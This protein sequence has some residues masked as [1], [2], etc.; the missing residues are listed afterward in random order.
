[1]K[2]RPGLMLSA[3]AI[4]LV[5]VAA[6]SATAQVSSRDLPIVAQPQQRFDSGQDIQPIYE[7]WE[8]NDNGG[9]TLHFG[10][11]NRNYREQPQVP[12]G[13]NN[14]FSPGDADR[15]QPAYFYPRTQRY[16]FTVQVPASTGASLEDGLVWTVIHRGSEQRAIGWLQPEWEIDENTITSLSRTGRGASV[17]DLF[18]NESPKVTVEAAA[19][20]VAVGQ[21]LMLTAVLTDDDLPKKKPARRG[22]PTRLPSLTPPE[23]AVPKPNNIRSYRKPRPPQDGLSVEWIVYRGPE[24]AD[25][26]PPGFQRSVPGEDGNRGG[27]YESSGPVSHEPQLVAGDGW[28]TATFETA[29]TFDTPGTYTLRA[30]ACDAMM[31]TPADLTVTVTR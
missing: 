20:T 3:A 13:P 2:V 10:Y 31:I 25:F 19:S 28:T 24:D 11:F 30:Y 29:V 16:A 12:I 18:A 17:E 8:K 22:T 7:G 6:S 9:F 4:S 1:M 27:Y 23:G 5:A 15:G 21:P 26:D 14:H